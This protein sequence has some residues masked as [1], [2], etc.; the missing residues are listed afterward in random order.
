MRIMWKNNNLWCA[1]KRCA[2]VAICCF[3][4]ALLI[5]IP[6]KA[7]PSRE[8]P[9]DYNLGAGPLEISSESPGQSVRYSPVP[10]IPEKI[11]PGSLETSL[12]AS[13]ANIWTRDER[14]NLDY[15]ILHTRFSLSY[16]VTPRLRLTAAY[17]KRKYFGGAMDGFLI[18]FH[19]LVGVEQDGRDE[20]PR[21]EAHYF[22]ADTQKNVIVDSNDIEVFDNDAIQIGASYLLMPGSRFWPAINLTGTVSWGLDTPLIGSG[23]PVDF[24]LGVGLSKRWARKWL[25]YHNFTYIR[26][27]QNELHYF[28]LQDNGFSMVNAIVWEWRPNVSVP[29]QFMYTSGLVKDTPNLKDS[30]YEAHIGLKWKMK[31]HGQL[32][33][34]LIENVINYDNSPDF[35]IHLNYSCSL[36]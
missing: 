22:F 9:F 34:A 2:R 8:M 13:W 32:E 29:L 11:I 14:Y 24:A 31:R 15:E 4:L 19:D 25:T 18:W 12:G 7:F 5:L 17:E 28:S 3:G 20:I 16:G 33:V 23:E 36:K 1:K 35:G 6:M 26:F 27:G 21:N 10:G 30:S